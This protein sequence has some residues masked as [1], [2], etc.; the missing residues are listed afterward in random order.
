MRLPEMGIGPGLVVV[1][2]LAGTPAIA[3]AQ[4]EIKS[5]A[6]EITLT[7]RLNAQFNTTSISDE[8]SNE[9]FVRR[10]RVTAEIQVNDFVSGK[11][12]PDFGEGDI[13]LKDAYLHLTFDPAFQ[14]KFGQLK[15]AFDVF[16]ITSSTLIPVI[17]RD[18]EVRGVNTCR[19]TGGQCTFDTLVEGLEYS[20]RDIGIRFEGHD[21][22]ERFGYLVSLTNGAGD[23]KSEE[24]DGKSFAGRIEVTPIGQLSVAANVS[25]HDFVNDSTGDENDYAFAYGGDLEW[26]NYSEGLHVIAG[27]AAGDNWLNLNGSGASSTFVTA[28]GIVTYKAPI[29]GNPFVKAIETV[30]RVSWGDSDTDANASDSQGWLFTPGLQLF[31]VGRNKFA[32]NVDVWSPKRGG[33]E[34][35]FKAQAYLHF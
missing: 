33:T 24:N 9:F 27:V 19:G 22:D 20:D 26:G 14:M 13:A 34:W 4:V 29:R 8:I 2:A 32:V 16:Q 10:A 35:S 15:R 12:Q 23:N 18:G 31:F 7:G 28:Q 25:V 3:T 5:R 6:M 30:G 17:E 11:I 21:R 1:V